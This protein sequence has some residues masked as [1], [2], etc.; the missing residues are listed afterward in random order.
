MSNLDFEYDKSYADWKGWNNNFQP[1]SFDKI[2]YDGEFKANSLN[3]LRVLEIGFGSGSFMAWAR[4]AGAIIS[5]CE[6]IQDLCLAG[7]AQGYDTRFGD[8][9]VFSAELGSFDLIVA[10]D[11]MEHIPTENLI[12]F[13][14][15]VKS[16][17]KQGGSFV[18]RVP[19]GASPWGLNNQ[20]G[21]ITHVSV[22][23]EGRFRQLA[24]YSKLN[25][26]GCNN[27]FRVMRPGSRIAD[28]LKFVLRD[29]YSRSLSSVFGLWQ[30]PLDQNIIAR[31][32]KNN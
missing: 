31:F 8:L 32:K 30:V 24:T 13:M 25:F 9:N 20:Y 28:K 15:Q 6:L 27:A 18:A 2:Y 29:I 22:L 5:G 1:N 10:L 12:D 16:L 11:V 17:L 7:I 14:I 23:T 21:D 4:Q 26:D 19:N 3:G